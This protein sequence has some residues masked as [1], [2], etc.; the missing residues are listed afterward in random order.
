M[1][2]AGPSSATLA[3]MIVLTSVT[4]ASSTMLQFSSRILMPGQRS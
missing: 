4:V 1:A 3:A 2:G